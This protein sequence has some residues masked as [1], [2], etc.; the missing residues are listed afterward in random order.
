MK[1]DVN[2]NCSLHLCCNHF[3]TYLFY[4]YKFSVLLLI[5]IFATSAAIAQKPDRFLQERAGDSMWAVNRF[6]AAPRFYIGNEKVNW[7]TWR[8]HLKKGDKEAGAIITE[9]DRKRRTGAWIGG[10]GALVSLVGLITLSN[11]TFPGTSQQD[12]ATSIV[13]ISAGFVALV[14]G[15][16][17][18]ASAVRKMNSGIRLFN[19]KSAKGTLSPVTLKV[20]AGP[21]QA[22]LVLRW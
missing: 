12:G 16:I 21:T 3:Y 15:A 1:V 2:S 6:F 10:G 14:T 7:R 11:N 5:G 19:S 13:M 18:E 4:M 9:A 17:M 8:D 22:G 20:H